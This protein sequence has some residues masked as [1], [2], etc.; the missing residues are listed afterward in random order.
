MVTVARTEASRDFD[1]HTEKLYDNYSINKEEFGVDLY[2]AWGGKRMI[3]RRQEPYSEHPPTLLI[4]Y[5]HP[6]QDEGSRYHIEERCN[7]G[8]RASDATNNLG[9]AL[10]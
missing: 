1:K 6:E 7:G 2:V 9:P 3:A 5:L 10:F 4:V 8:N